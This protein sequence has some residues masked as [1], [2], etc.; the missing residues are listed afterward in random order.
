MAF[1]DWRLTGGFHTEKPVLDGG[2]LVI[3]Y[4]ADLDAMEKKV[5]AAGAVIVERHSF[6]GGRRFHFRDPN[7]NVLAVWSEK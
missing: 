1:E 5:A 6:P 2:A 4:A 3:L 7:G